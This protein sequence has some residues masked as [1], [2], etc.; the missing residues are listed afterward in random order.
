MGAVFAPPYACLSIGY[1]EETKLEPTILPLYFSREDVILIM[2]LFLRYIDDGFIPW[3]RRLRRD[4][5]IT[6]LNSLDS[7][8]RFTVVVGMLESIKRFIV[9]E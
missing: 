9:P 4:H 6:A 5:F 3:P 8:I 7:R 2:H 1:L